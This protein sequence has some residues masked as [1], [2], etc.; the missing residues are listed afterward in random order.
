MLQFVSGATN[1]KRRTAIYKVRAKREEL[2]AESE[3]FEV[4]QSKSGLVEASRN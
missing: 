1:V 3:E 4:S 2:P